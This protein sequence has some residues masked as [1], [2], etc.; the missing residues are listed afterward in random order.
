M[1]VSVGLAGG[2]PLL[3]ARRRGRRAAVTKK[4]NFGS[5]SFDVELTDLNQFG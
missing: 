3:E 1:A 4:D 5:S 2:R